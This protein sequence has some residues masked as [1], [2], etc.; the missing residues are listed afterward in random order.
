MVFS[1]EGSVSLRTDRNS[2]YA[3]PASKRGI[4]H[5]RGDFEENSLDHHIVLHGLDHS[6]VNIVATDPHYQPSSAAAVTRRAMLIALGDDP[7]ELVR[8]GV[9]LVKQSVRDQARPHI[10]HPGSSK[11]QLHTQTNTRAQEDYIQTQSH[12]HAQSWR[13]RGG[14]ERGPGDVITPASLTFLLM[15]T[16]IYVALICDIIHKSRPTTFIYC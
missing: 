12:R 8:R 9:S 7:F 14:F 4:S 6:Y 11:A 3:M 5:L 15:E 13:A 2:T 10:G 16:C 1:L